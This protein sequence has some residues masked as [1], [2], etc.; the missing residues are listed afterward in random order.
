MLK[1]HTDDYFAIGAAHLTSGKPCQDYATSREEE[2]CAIVVVSD[3]C[4]TGNRT[5][6]GARLVSLQAIGSVVSLPAAKQMLGLSNSDMLAT[7]VIA[8]IGQDRLLISVEGDGVVAVKRKGEDIRM[9]RFEWDDNTPFY[10][11]Y[12]EQDREQFIKV[13][14]GVANAVRLQEEWVCFQNGRRVEEANAYYSVA[15]GMMGIVHPYSMWELELVAV[16][17]DGVTQIDNVPWTEAVLEFMALKTTAGEFAK[18]RMMRALK[19]MRERGKGPIDDI[20]CAMIC[21]EEVEV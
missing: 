2:G 12:T 15:Q 14:G 4:S 1:F 10:P 20:S 7:R 8:S 5:D 19:G 17:S 18:R 13:H 9:S 3:G 11:A 21:V 6:I 16:F